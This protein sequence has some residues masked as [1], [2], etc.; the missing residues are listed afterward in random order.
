MQIVSTNIG[1]PREVLWKGKKIRT[2][3][4]KYPTDKGIHL[5]SQGVTDDHVADRKH[6]GGH[7]KACYIYSV[8]HYQYWKQLF[9]NADWQYGMFGEN[10]SID[11][12]DE[13]NHYIGSRYK[14]GEA[15]VEISQPREPC[16]KLGIRFNTQE[17]V[18][19]FIKSPYPGA[20]I[21]IL[22]AGQVQAGDRMELISMPMNRLSIASA[23]ALLSAKDPD[24]NQ[25]KAAL[26]NPHLAESFKKSIT[27]LA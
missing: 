22:K 19:Q 25:L 18:R 6:H 5:S 12:F 27:P 24:G 21:R 13:A 17:I 23:F 8:D 11:D 1:K 14:L 9:P 15:L 16:Y 10:L 20:Y 26:E 2:G 3:I 7:D 4:Y